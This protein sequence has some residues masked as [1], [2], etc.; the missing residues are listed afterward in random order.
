[1]TRIALCIASRGNPRSLFET[2]HANLRGC[3]L[4]ETKAVVGLDEDDPT[5]PDARTLL[6][7]L[8]A[9]RIIVSIAPRADTIGAVYNRCAAAIDAGL[10]LNWVDDGKFVTPGWDAQLS[11]AARNYPDGIGMIGFGEMPIPSWL[12]AGEATTRGLI[13][14]MGYYIQDHTPYWWMDTWL[15]E[16]AVMIGRFQSVPLGIE[17]VG[18]RQTRGLRELLYWARFFDEMRVHRRATAEAILASPDFL[19]SAERK[20]ALR[21]NLDYVCTELEKSNAIL[22]DPDHAK[23]LEGFGYDAPADER[24]RRAK[25]R[26]L[27]VLQELERDR[28]RV[29]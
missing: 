25:D 5:L 14:K 4:P 1:M 3:A 11:V 16:I 17:F 20:Q 6:D 24:Y 22:R 18:Q 21:D 29:A 13:D 9:E 2:L 12:P 27:A 26:S 23:R 8:G 19:E 28:A 15:C 7:A 10:Y